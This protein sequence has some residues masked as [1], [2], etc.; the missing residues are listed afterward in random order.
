LQANS[1]ARRDPERAARD[2]GS[3]AV[4]EPDYTAGSG[5]AAELVALRK[6]LA[7]LPILKNFVTPPASSGS[8]L[9]RELHGEIDELVDV[10]ERLEK[11][12]ADEPP[13]MANDP[14]I[15]RGGITR[16]WTS[17]GI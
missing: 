15:I 1:C 4:D 9:L 2:T 3:G 6:S 14:G 17:C 5:D 11:A 8:D 13:A 10:R 16:S 12:L 7:Q